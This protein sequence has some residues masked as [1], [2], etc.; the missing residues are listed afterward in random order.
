MGNAF[1]TKPNLAQYM[2]NTVKKMTFPALTTWETYVLVSSRISLYFTNSAFSLFQLNPFSR[3]PAP[4]NLAG[5]LSK[6]AQDFAVN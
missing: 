5:P 6:H 2:V 4:S 1:A 3:E